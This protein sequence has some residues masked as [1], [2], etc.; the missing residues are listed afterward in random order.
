MNV[1]HSTELAFVFPS[2]T[3]KEFYTSSEI[4]LVGWMR[5]WWV[6]FV[7]YGTPVSNSSNVVWEPFRILSFLSPSLPPF[8]LFYI[9][10]GLMGSRNQILQL[11]WHWSTIHHQPRRFWCSKQLWILGHCGTFQEVKRGREKRGE[12]TLL[13]STYLCF[14][15]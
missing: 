4:E 15:R 12:V 9:Y 10:I 8:S 11:S 6:S 3:Y 1:S 5:D 2:E 14:R 7:S 13:H